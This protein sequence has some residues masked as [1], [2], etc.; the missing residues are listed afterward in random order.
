MLGDPN[1]IQFLVNPNDKTIAIHTSLPDDHLSQH[2]RWRR[3]RG[4]QCCEFYSKVLIDALRDVGLDWDNQ[5]AYKLYGHLYKKMSIVR[6]S[7][8]DYV[9]I[10]EIDEG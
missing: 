4:K 5:H 9:I 7:M 1:Y 3:L 2:V 10:N 6:F 8:S